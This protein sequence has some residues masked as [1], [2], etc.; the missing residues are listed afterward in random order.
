MQTYHF[1]NKQV[2]NHHTDGSKE[3]TFPDGTTR[4]V[5]TDGSSD[6]IF[7]DGVRVSDYPDGTLRV[8]QGC[9]L[10]ILVPK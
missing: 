3:I 6:T 8:I 2:E 1:P 5:H 7:P 10:F 9:Y 4:V